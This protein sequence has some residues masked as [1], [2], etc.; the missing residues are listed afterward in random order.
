MWVTK[1]VM[2]M[3]CFYVGFYVVHM[4]YKVSKVN[5]TMLSFLPTFV[6][7]LIVHLLII[8]PIV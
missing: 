6:A 5:W 3:S 4:S 7:N 8:A 1:F 2:L